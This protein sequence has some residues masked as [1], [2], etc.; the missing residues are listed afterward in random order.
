MNNKGF[1]LI[2][3]M[4]V[5]VIIGI[6]AAIAIPNFISM[7]DRAKEGSVKANM[8]TIQLTV[9]DYS[10][11]TEGVYPM[12][13]NTA[14]NVANPLM[15]KT[16]S[17]AGTPG[18]TKSVAGNLLPVNVINPIMK[19]TAWAFSS[20][21]VAAA[22]DPAGINDPG[23]GASGDQGSV[24]YGS[25]TAEGAAAIATTAA[26]YRIYGYGVKKMMPVPLT[27]GQ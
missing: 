27:S 12:D 25:A 3:L 1:T 26:R 21:G 13:F 8:H 15:T 20:A 24:W 19:S 10:V 7:Q 23:T 14:I 22:T 16:A 2:E 11:Q 5:V 18:A 4:I 17:V 6:L 9:E